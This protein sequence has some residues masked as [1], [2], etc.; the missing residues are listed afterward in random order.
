MGTRWPLPPPYYSPLL[1]IPYLFDRDALLTYRRLISDSV[2]SQ[3]SLAVT[4]HA[5]SAAG[6]G[7]PLDRRRL[8]LAQPPALYVDAI[9][10]AAFALNNRPFA[11]AFGG[12]CFGMKAD[13]ASAQ[14][15]PVRLRLRILPYAG[16]AYGI[17][18]TLNFVLLLSTSV[19]APATRIPD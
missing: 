10:L 6:Q 9:Q 1:S 2:S 19:V 14:P 16:L 17:S 3:P 13:G 12:L 11:A 7:A 15:G 8:K 18:F 5:G 4:R